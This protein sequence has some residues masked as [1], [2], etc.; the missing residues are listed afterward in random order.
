MDKCGK[1]EYINAGSET[2]E[3]VNSVPPTPYVKVRLFAE[4]E[5][6]K[7]KVFALKSFYHSLPDELCIVD[8]L[9]AKQVEASNCWNGNSEAR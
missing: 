7:M 4:M 1:P 2:T 5:A 8:E 6:A 9:S 3:Y